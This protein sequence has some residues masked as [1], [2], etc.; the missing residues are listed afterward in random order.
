[1]TEAIKA[2]YNGYT[3]Y[4]YGVSS[5]SIRDKNDKEIFHTGFLRKRPTN[6]AECLQTLKEML[7]FFNIYGD[8]SEIEC[9]KINNLLQKSFLNFIL[10][11]SFFLSSS[12]S[13]S[14][15]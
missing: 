7:D 10:Q 6:E 12:V 3:G 13:K 4:A 8:E 2:E 5:F 15:S 14:S 9:I 1:M 11:A